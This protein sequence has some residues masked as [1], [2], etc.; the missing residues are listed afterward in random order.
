MIYNPRS[1]N[2][3][4]AMSYDFAT[5]SDLEIISFKSAKAAENLTKALDKKLKL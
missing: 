1:Q 4:F 5:K 3:D 2:W